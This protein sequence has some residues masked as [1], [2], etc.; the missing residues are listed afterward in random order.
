[1]EMNITIELW[2][3]ENGFVAKCP[4]LDL[5]A[6]GRTREE[7]RVNLLE[8]MEI[9]FQEM[10]KL[11]QL[12]DSLPERGSEKHDSTVTPQVELVAWEKHRVKVA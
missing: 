4:E 9:R 3:S 2:Q 1:M 10:V 7:A 5:A 12:N 11:G 6:Q 8:I